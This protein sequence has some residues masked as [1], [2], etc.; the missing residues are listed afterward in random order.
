M[1]QTIKKH[2]FKIQIGT[3][4]LVIGFIVSITASYTS[5]ADK[6]NTL[7][8]DFREHEKSEEIRYKEFDDRIDK[9]DIQYVEIKTKLISIESL[10]A[11]LK[12]NI[13]K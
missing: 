4:V 11:D 2:A 6:M 10:L 1:E 12:N 13:N 3:A 5:K 8:E 7:D 9:T